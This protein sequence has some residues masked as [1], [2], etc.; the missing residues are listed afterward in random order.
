MPENAVAALGN[1]GL[2]VR[3]IYTNKDYAPYPVKR[4]EEVQAWAET[5]GIQFLRLDD[6]V[7]LAPD[8]VLK[9]DGLPYTVFTPYSKKWHKVLAAM[10]ADPMAEET[11]DLTG[12]RGT[13]AHRRP[14]AFVG[15]HGL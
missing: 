12:K 9:D 8:A 7:V 1:S 5:K 11:V 14:L 4:D 10:D 3:A 6:H 13:R 15:G 2:H